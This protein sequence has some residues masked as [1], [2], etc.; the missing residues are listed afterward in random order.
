MH[1]F[2]SLLKGRGSTKQEGSERTVFTNLPDK[3]ELNRKCSLHLLGRSSL[4]WKADHI[5]AWFFPVEKKRSLDLISCLSLP[6]RSL[7]E[8]N[9]LLSLHP[10]Q[11]TLCEK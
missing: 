7:K 6:L 2:N 4:D 8:A 3:S 9:N 10:P 1:G 5:A 11:Q